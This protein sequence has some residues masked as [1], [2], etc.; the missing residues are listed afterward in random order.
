MSTL[1][2]P[3]KGKILAS[4]LD[5]RV[6]DVGERSIPDVSAVNNVQNSQNDPKLIDD[7]DVVHLPSYRWIFDNPMRVHDADD[8]AIT[9]SRI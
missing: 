6:H 3:A 1:S 4:A 8:G 7:Q 5:S 2:C 9:F